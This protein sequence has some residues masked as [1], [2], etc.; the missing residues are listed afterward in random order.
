MF[1]LSSPCSESEL[2][3]NRIAWLENLVQVQEKEQNYAEIAEIHWNIFQMYDKVR[4]IWPL[5]WA[6]RERIPWTK[7]RVG[8]DPQRSFLMTMTRSVHSTGRCWN[9][10]QEFLESMEQHLV[11]CTNGF[12]SIGLPNLAERS[13]RKTIE[14]LLRSGRVTRSV[15]QYSDFAAKLAGASDT[16]VAVALG[17]YYRVWYI[18]QAIPENLRSKEFIYR[19]SKSLHLQDFGNALST[20]LQKQL[21]D[22]MR[23]TIVLDTTKIPGEF[24]LLVVVTLMLMPTLCSGDDFEAAAIVIMS[25]KPLPMVSGSEQASDQVAALNQAQVFQ[26]AV[27]FTRDG[28]T[29][30]RSIAQQWKRV[31]LFEVANPFPTLVYRQKIIRKTVLTLEPIEVALDD[32]KIRNESMR[33]ELNRDKRDGA[34]TQNLMRI[35]QGSVMPQVNGGVLEVAKVFLPEEDHE[36]DYGGPS[37]LNTQT[38]QDLQM[39][40]MSFLQL[41]RQLLEKASKILII[42]AKI[43]LTTADLNGDDDAASRII[44]L[45]K[46][47]QEHEN[48]VIWVREMEK[49]Y[50]GLLRAMSMYLSEV[51]G[52][53]TLEASSFGTSP[54]ARHSPKRAS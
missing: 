28:G 5:L 45:R 54:S 40:I 30:A 6:P 10:E 43:T 22:D 48:N 29:H 47:Q 4:D 7:C 41:S 49:G 15:T 24:I 51:P 31:T 2:C 19:N 9:S 35:I 8:D 52:F 27:P 32:V 11:L 3:R 21:D 18:G 36:D 39:S 25:V 50:D 12:L 13:H 26:H 34:D 20:Q 38:K 53:A 1:C 44:A 42:D 37:K 17:L 16:S 23:I 46:K 14:I 33:V